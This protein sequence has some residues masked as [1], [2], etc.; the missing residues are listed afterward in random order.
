MTESCPR[1]HYFRIW[2][3][4]VSRASDRQERSQNAP[5]SWLSGSGTP[6]SVPGLHKPVRARKCGSAYAG[7]TAAL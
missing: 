5:T 1:N 2:Q 7:Q 4:R 6:G 3:K